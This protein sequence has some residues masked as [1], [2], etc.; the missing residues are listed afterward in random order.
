M[1]L[2]TLLV[3][4]AA[5]L[6]GCTTPESRQ[7]Q[8]ILQHKIHLEEQVH[9]IMVDPSDGISEE[10]AYKIGRERFDTYRIGCGI[11]TIPADLGDY[12]RV[13]TCVGYVGMPF[14]DILIR[15][16]DGL[17]TIK[18]ADVQRVPNKALESTAAAP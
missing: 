15:K 17:T 3:L 18:K 16:S 2:A 5:T 7:R 11:V 8:E 14:E 9:T 6:V 12:W 13:T 4:S 10:E 1:K